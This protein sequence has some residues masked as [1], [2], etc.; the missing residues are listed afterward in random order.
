VPA[1]LLNVATAFIDRLSTLDEWTVLLVTFLSS[2]AETT[3]LLGLLVPG[4][5]VIMLAGSLPDGPAGIALAVVVG[6]AGALTGQTCGYAVGRVFG[7]R[8]RGTRLGRRI[9]AERFD[10]AE[11][12]LRDRGAPALVAVRF[13]AV[14]H[15][16]VPIM[17]GVARMPFGRFL[18]WSALGTT[19]WVGAFAGLGVVTADADSSGGLGIVLTAVGAT[20]LGVVP[21]AARLIRR[22]FA[23]RPDATIGSAIR[24]V[25]P[26]AA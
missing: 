21:I 4:E 26:Q 13:V 10:R 8:L 24:P 6:T 17:A 23:S 19:L 2:A 18:L 5:S 3:F 14:I 7:T 22:A 20:C 25:E 16:V 15:A 9:G 11:A 1:D 12:Y